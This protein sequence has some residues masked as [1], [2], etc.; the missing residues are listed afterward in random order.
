MRRGIWG[1]V[2]SLPQTL[3]PD[4]IGTA[5]EIDGPS[6]DGLRMACTQLYIVPSWGDDSLYTNFA[7]RHGYA[8]DHKLE[9][10]LTILKGHGIQ[11]PSHPTAELL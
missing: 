6:F 1:G 8:F 11:P 3:R 7:V 9:Q 5:L 10:P 4:S 2:A